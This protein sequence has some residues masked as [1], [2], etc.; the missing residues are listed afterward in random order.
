MKIAICATGNDLKAQVSSFFGRCP[1]FLIIDSEDKK[2]KVEA[3]PNPALSA[4]RGAGVVAV[5]AVVEK[6]IKAIICQG[7]GP[8][9]FAVIQSAG[10]SFYMVDSPMTIQEVLEAFRH[11]KL[12][13][14]SSPTRTAG[15]FGRQAGMGRGRGFGRYQS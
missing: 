9:A 4:G 13:P 7:I 15:G 1:Y 10:I 11:D 8:N 6:E 2:E 5:Q 14:V 12:K 3:I